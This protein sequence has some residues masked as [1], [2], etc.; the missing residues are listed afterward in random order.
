M[1][2]TLVEGDQATEWNLAS[3]Q[4]RALAETGWVDVDT[5]WAGTWQLKAKSSVGAARVGDIDL[6]IAPKLPIARLLFLLGYAANDRHWLSTDAAFG[7][8]AGMVPAMADAYARQV[9]RALAQGVLQGY[10][11]VDEALPL[12]RGRIRTGDQIG[13]RY[14]MALPIEVTY[15]EFDTD[16]P[17][18]QILRHA[19]SL[20]LGVPGVSVGARRRLAHML[21]QLADVKPLHAGLQLPT[22][23][24]SRLNARYHVALRLAELIIA[25]TSIEHRVGDVRASGIMLDL[26]RLFESFVTIA[27]REAWNPLGGRTVGQDRWHLDVD[28]TI[29]MRPDVV[30]YQAEASAPAIVV[31]AKYKA[32]KPSGFPNADVY[33]MLAYCT[34]L[35][36]RHGHLVYA[37]GNE[38]V[39]TH[40][41][42]GGDI[43][44]HQ[45]VLD[46]DQQPEELLAS[47]ADLAQHMTATTPE[48][49]MS[50]VRATVSRCITAARHSGSNTA[51]RSRRV[52]WAGSGEARRA[53][54]RNTDLPAQG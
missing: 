2:V 20:L 17:E 27:L 5:S 4:A 44:I 42:H 34:R 25:S 23:R 48:S 9:E 40:V 31:D 6:H 50:A 18:N 8:S 38:P 43:T 53:A 54:T 19:A 24:P 33:Q 22:W 35:A 12:V 10:R 52:R 3:A 37:A 1:N 14:G 28:D 32:E 47:V 16:I 13:R 36:L 46:L 39:Q 15:D 29:L 45:H 21:T 26:A 49:E 11:T 30:W 41:I 51:Y 7:D